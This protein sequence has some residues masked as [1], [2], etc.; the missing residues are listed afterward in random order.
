MK[1]VA[2]FLLCVRLSSAETG[3]GGGGG[4]WGGR[5]WE[6]HTSSYTSDSNQFQSRAGRNFCTNE[7]EVPRLEKNKFTEV[8][9]GGG[10]GNE[11]ERGRKK[12][13]LD[14]NLQIKKQS[15]QSCRRALIPGRS[16]QA[17][18]E[19]NRT[20]LEYA[21]LLALSGRQGE[22]EGEVEICKDKWAFLRTAQRP[23]KSLLSQTLINHRSSRY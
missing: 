12:T 11:K 23:A 6:K 3:G 18:A 5:L 16:F 22:V 20:R 14:S 8:K 9:R 2:E 15:N 4:G 13:S 21:N 10:G 19:W 17:A 7:P 1:V